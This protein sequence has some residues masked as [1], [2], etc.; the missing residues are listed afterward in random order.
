MQTIAENSRFST[1]KTVSL[2]ISSKNYRNTAWSPFFK[3]VAFSS[4]KY[5]VGDK[6]ILSRFLPKNE[7]KY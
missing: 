3:K 1:P 5:F 4:S 7:K 2:K 6:V